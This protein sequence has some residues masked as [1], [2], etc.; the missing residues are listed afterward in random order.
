ML[1][2]VRLLRL[3][4]LFVAVLASAASGGQT[5]TS[6][7]PPPM[8]AP[9]GQWNGMPGAPVPSLEGQGFS[10]TDGTDRINF[11]FRK[12]GILHY[13]DPQGWWEDGSWQQNGVQVTFLLGDGFTTYHGQVIGNTISGDAINKKGKTWRFSVQQGTSRLPG[14]IDLSGSTWGGKEDTKCIVFSFKPGGVLEYDTPSGHYTDGTWLIDGTWVFVKHK[15]TGFEYF[16]N[17]KG[18][19]MNGNLWSL[20]GQRWK[21][22]VGKGVVP[23]D[24]GK[25][26]AGGKGSFGTGTTGST[27]STS[28]TTPPAPAVASIEGSIWEGDNGGDAT[29]LKFKAGGVLHARDP[30]G[31]WKGSW[32]QNGSQI[33]FDLNGHYSWYEGTV[34][35]ET[36]S[37]AGHNK[38]GLDWKFLVKRK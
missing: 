3:I 37:G 5:A 1:A 14:S 18:E 26:V 33:T 30:Q 10:G 15:A 12:G 36:M 21:W 31:D 23:P 6:G 4:V 8:G 9:Q 20:K 2:D 28:T 35:G 11:Y 7:P 25:T 19:R 22:E 13:R 16:G 27:G 29:I 24:C 38:D 32:A 17:I 34:A